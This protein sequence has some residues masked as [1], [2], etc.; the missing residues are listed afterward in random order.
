MKAVDKRVMIGIIIVALLG[1]GFVGYRMLNPIVPE[2]P[3]NG[4]E[5]HDNGGEVPDT[6]GETPDTGGETPDTG[7]TEL[8]TVTGTVSDENGEGIAGVTVKLGD[9]T[10]T[11]N[12]DGVY[13]IKVS[14]GDY[15]LEVSKTSYSQGIKG[16]SVTDEGDYEADFTLRV[17]STAT[18]D[19]KSLRVITRHGKDIMDVTEEL[20]LLSDFAVENNIV[21]IDWLPVGPSL[22]VNTI[23]RSADI[24]VAWGGGP[25][26]FDT[27]MASDQLAPLDSENVLEII[28]TIPEDIGGSITRREVDDV[29]Y[30]S[31]AAVSSFGFTINT[32]LI[33][34]YGLP[35]PTTWADLGST[36][37]AAYLPTKLVGTADATKSTSNTR[38]F[39][40]ILQIY[41]WEEGWDLLI[42]MGANSLIFDQSGNVQDA[43]MN[44]QIA[45][46]T[47]IDFYG[48]TAQWNNPEYCKYIF[49]ADGTIVNADPIALLTTS[50][51]P[52]EAMGFIEWVLSSEGQKV[53][54][55]GNIN[56]LPINAAVF[57]TPEGIARSDLEA[58]YFQT[59]SALTV[60]FSDEIAASYETAMQNF[61]HAVIVRPQGKLD[62]VWDDLTYMLENGDI[63]QAE[64]D[65]I[66]FR[67]G[68]PLLFE[69]VDPDT[70]ETEIFSVEY[71]QSINSKI[72]TNV[73][74]KTQVIDAWIEA[75]NNHY[76]DIAAELASMG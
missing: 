49:P 24:D 12:A 39:T 47:T 51:Y 31:G 41:G 40:I 28:G 68:N 48:Y 61:Y 9:K 32:E 6:G 59:Q 2:V 34:Y 14:Q 19:G 10:A 57:D 35:E 71:A 72:A 60:E 30:W 67:L 1:V 43:V 38:M 33:D 25:V 55:D 23:S 18:G 53:W 76:D 63:T 26:L 70:G 74:Y 13:H 46:G 37:Y 3:D 20:F 11:T 29:I 75:A 8:A 45:V 62:Q 56:R 4:G 64:F 5:V 16:I 36:T 7:E 52:E 54:L 27:I 44:T 22:W 50:Q 65:D 42:K 73:E 21:N 69:F 66:S 15:Y 58:V 17:L